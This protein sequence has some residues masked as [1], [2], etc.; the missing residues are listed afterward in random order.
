MK[1]TLPQCIRLVIKARDHWGSVILG[2]VLITCH[3]PCLDL[4]SPIKEDFLSIL[5]NTFLPLEPRIFFP[6]TAMEFIKKSRLALPNG[7]MKSASSSTLP[8][9]FKHVQILITSF[10]YYSFR[11]T[12]F[13]LLSDTSDSSALSLKMN[14]MGSRASGSTCSGS[15]VMEKRGIFPPVYDTRTLSPCPL[16]ATFLSLSSHRKSQQHI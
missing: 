5:S 11:S 14:S 3:D 4:V 1:Q 10:F 9:C 13:T 2:V 8:E 12:L 7:A 15:F 6:S 16:S